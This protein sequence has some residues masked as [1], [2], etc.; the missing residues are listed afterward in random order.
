M[1]IDTSA[2]VAILFNE[3]DA[4]YFESALVSDPTR[5]MSAAS[6]LETAIV[7][8]ARL[9]EA[10]SQEFDQLLQTAQI[11]IVPVTAQQVE[12]GRQA[13]HTYGKGRHPAGLNYGDCFA[14]ALA[15]T[16]SEPLLFKG[17]DFSQTDISSW[18]F[19]QQ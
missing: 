10:G 8:E 9:G 19:P 4:E 5:L 17:N 14:Y 18:T 2:I 16:T 7:V 3:P 11:T 6:V 13:Y 1:V 15:K 12:I